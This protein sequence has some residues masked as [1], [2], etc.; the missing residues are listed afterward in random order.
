[1]I[2]RII[3]PSRS[4]RWMAPL[5]IGLATLVLAGLLAVPA[6]AGHATGYTVTEIGFGSSGRTEGTLIQVGESTWEEV[7]NSPT[8]NNFVFDETGRD[9]RNVYLEDP[10]RGVRLQVDLVAR[11]IFYGDANTPRRELYDVLGASDRING[12][13][14]RRVSYATGGKPMGILRDVGGQWE[15]IP[16]APNGYS[17]RFEEIGRNAEMVELE[18]T[19]RG[20]YLRIDLALGKIFYSD[21]NVSGRELYQIDGVWSQP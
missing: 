8:G 15:E 21:S 19:S 2:S 6:A 12:W 14:V 3:V 1:M 5:L 9:D 20:V 11:K 7:K 17:Y 16:K 4:I 13:I 18:D 10:S